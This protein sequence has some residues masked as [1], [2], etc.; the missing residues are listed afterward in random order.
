MPRR[1]YSDSEESNTVP[2]ILLGGSDDWPGWLRPVS[3]ERW[4]HILTEHSSGSM[5]GKS[6]F[7][8]DTDMTRAIFD[9]VTRGKLIYE[10]DNGKIWNLFVN[11]QL[12][13]VVARSEE[14]DFFIVTAYPRE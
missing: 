8:P 6:K 9:T 2:F 11:G 1:S 12:I 7:R 4:N 14:K 5:S 13:E 10:S 3:Q